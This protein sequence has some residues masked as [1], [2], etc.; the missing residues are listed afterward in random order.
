MSMVKTVETLFTMELSA[1]TAAAAIAGRPADP[2]PEPHCSITKDRL[3]PVLP[4][5]PPKQMQRC[6]ART[7]KTGI[8][9]LR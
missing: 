6:L 8:S 2:Q 3:R 4:D 7:A 5:Q 9:N 1:E